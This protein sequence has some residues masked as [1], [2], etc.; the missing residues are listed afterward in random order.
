MNEVSVYALDRPITKIEQ[1]HRYLEERRMD[2]SIRVQQNSMDARRQSQSKS[3]PW[4]RSQSAWRVVGVLR[5]APVTLQFPELQKFVP[6]AAVQ[7]YSKA[8]A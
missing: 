6:S 8:L 4:L 7:M 2:R 3:R 1:C 5:G